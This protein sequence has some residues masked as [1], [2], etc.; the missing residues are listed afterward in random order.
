MTVYSYH[1]E[2]SSLVMGNHANNGNW[3]TLS[4]DLNIIPR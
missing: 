2:T 1:L 3:S 4:D